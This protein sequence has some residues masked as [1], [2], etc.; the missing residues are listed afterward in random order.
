MSEAASPTGRSG[1]R[2]L[3]PPEVLGVA[4]LLRDQGRW[5]EAEKAYRNVLSRAPDDFG[6]YLELGA[7]CLQQ[8]RVGEA[9][10]NLRR[11]L[12]ID[13]N[14][15]EA[16]H[17]LGRAL[18]ALDRQAEALTFYERAAA[19]D[20][21][22]IDARNKLG[23]SLLAE[24]RAEEA[25]IHFEAAIG[26]APERAALHNNL[27]NALAALRR[28]TEALAAY[29]RALE[30]APDFAEA[31]YNR[32]MTLTALAR[33]D[34]AIPH[35][36]QALES[37]PDYRKARLGLGFA[38][39][40]RER[41]VEAIEQLEEVVASGDA[42]ADV[43]NDLGS[44]L[45]SAGR[46]AEAAARFREATA[47]RPDF[48]A[49]HN[50]LGNALFALD[51]PVEAVAAYR[52]AVE[53]N[54]TFAEAWSNLGAALA[55]LSRPRDALSCFERA[56][57]IDPHIAEAHGNR[58]FAF[59]A[60]GHL[61]DA[62]EAFTRAIALAPD[63]TGYYRGLTLC[64]R[65]E[66]DDPHFAAM[67]KLASDLSPGGDAE[68]IDLRFGLARVYEEHG[69][70]DE[71]FAH[72]V[73]ANAGRRKLH[74]YDAATALGMIRRVRET[75]TPALLRRAGVRGVEPDAPIFIV[76]MPRSGSTLVEQIL[77]SHPD[78]F[79]GGERLYLVGE[80]SAPRDG[81]QPFPESVLEMSNDEL[82]ALGARYRRRLRALA[83][84]APRI[85]DKLPGN[86]LFAGLIAL[87]LPDARIIHTRRDPLD[88]C[89]SCFAQNFAGL[90]FSNDLGDLGRY[91]RAYAG[92]MAHWREAL[93]ANFML[94]V[95]YE[96]LV[97]DFEPNARRIL[98]Y[99]GLAWDDRCLSFHRNPRPILTASAAQVRQPLYQSS[100][101]RA[102]AYGA[103]LQ[104]LIEALGDL[105]SLG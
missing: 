18:A 77:A 101:G 83:P 39:G 65:L 82:L 76:G 80:A 17:L 75:F 5:E 44:Y 68:A 92:L 51:D 59:I 43:L 96:D 85:T 13:P 90:P 19:L 46:R 71:A 8:D 23:A 4:R 14:S 37:R 61:S 87:A 36:R 56:L 58:G 98:D 63:R 79:G 35:F 1:R 45:A 9:E 47:L 2:L 73:G 34:E 70:F 15:A 91:Y 20:P 30:R 27:G 38:L 66:R 16:C 69:Q 49:A 103:M 54:P 100:T 33:L 11:A 89:L 41:F 88:T 102:R 42:G 55:S 86:F 97:A 24:G 50:N 72:L 64:G 10:T 104:P 25:R 40:G 29:A 74:P 67:E 57:A 21:S 99:C 6:A 26:L 31:H 60:L 48:A 7:L 32:G 94:E 28:P 3:T 12:A 52:R 62:R 53:L 84:Q 93:P 78:V 22:H 105:S 81:S 95:G